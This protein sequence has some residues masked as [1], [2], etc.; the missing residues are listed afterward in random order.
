MDGGLTQLAENLQVFLAKLYCLNA[1]C[2][3]FSFSQLKENDHDTE[4]IHP[5]WYGYALPA[6]VLAG[7]W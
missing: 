4:S 3:R 6:S 7:P 2:P 5:P 1:L